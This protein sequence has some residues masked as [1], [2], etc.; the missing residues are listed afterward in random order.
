MIG[1]Q[2]GADLLIF[3]NVYMQERGRGMARPLNNTQSIF[4]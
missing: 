1:K 3:G 4:E 2:T